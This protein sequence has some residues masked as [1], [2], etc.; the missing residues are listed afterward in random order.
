[1]L[2]KLTDQALDML[3]SHEVNELLPPALIRELI[4]LPDAIMTLHRPTPDIRLDAL[5]QGKHPA[6]KRLAFEELLAHNLSLLA[7]RA[8]TQ[9]HTAAALS[10]AQTL[11]QRFLATLPFT[12]TAA[13]TRVC[14]EL[15]VR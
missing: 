6:Q 5:E 1:M 3:K 12:P 15:E 13:Q 4:S 14:Q 10:P 2:R 7:A 9:A 11:Q 8:G